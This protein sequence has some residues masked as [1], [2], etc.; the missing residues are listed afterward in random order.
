MSVYQQSINLKFRSET[1]WDYFNTVGNWAKLIP[2]YQNH[3]IVNNQ[4]FLISFNINFGIIKRNVKIEVFD[5]KKR[6]PNLMTFS[7]T[8]ES[9]TI[10]G[11]GQ[12]RIRRI[13][14]NFTNVFLSL[15]IKADGPMAPF[16]ENFINNQSQQGLNREVIKTLNKE[17]Q[18][19]VG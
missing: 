10:S 7:F 12:L 8:S 9:N 19:F 17:L 3:E 18:E 1:V 16:I 15:N 13:N 11:T 5:L 6:K 2:G 14:A 4:I